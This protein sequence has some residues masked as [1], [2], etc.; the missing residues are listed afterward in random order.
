MRKVAAPRE[1]GNGCRT[2]VKRFDARSR[3]VLCLQAVGLVT[4]ALP[5]AHHL[6]ENTVFGVAF[7]LLRVLLTA[8]TGAEWRRSSERLLRHFWAGFTLF[9]LLMSCFAAFRLVRPLWG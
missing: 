4:V 6:F 8:S 7:L 5:E 3:L 9:W 2:P 1:L